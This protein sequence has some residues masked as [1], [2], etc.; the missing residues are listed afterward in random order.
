MEVDCIPTDGPA[1]VHFKY[2]LFGQPLSNLCLFDSHLM[3]QRPQSADGSLSLRLY[4]N[5]IA[6][7]A[8]VRVVDIPSFIPK[9]ANL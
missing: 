9:D 7:I 4:F 5:S 3:S 6:S 2:M 1:R 8:A